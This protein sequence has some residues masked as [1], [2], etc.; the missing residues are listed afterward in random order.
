MN[1]GGYLTDEEAKS[2][3][4]GRY[5]LNEPA[6]VADVIDGETIIMNLEKGDYYSLNPSGGEIWLHLLAGRRRDELLAAI[7]ERHGDVSS[8]AEV[9][10]FIARLIEYR[11]IVATEQP[12]DVNGLAAQELG[13]T[14]PWSKPEISVYAD[15]KDLLALDPPMPPLRPNRS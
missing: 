13:P 1:R 2:A 10:G 15:M 7:A 6:V 4:Q 11:L 12:G 3:A 8:P 14:A 5:R 9:D